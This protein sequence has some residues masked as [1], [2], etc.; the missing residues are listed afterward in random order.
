MFKIEIFK[1]GA[2]Q[3]FDPTMAASKMYGHAN[4]FL[5]AYYTVMQPLCRETGL[6]PLAVDILM[7]VA[8]N[9]E[10]ATARD[11]CRFRGFKPGI[12]SFH[13]DRLAGEGLVARQ[14]VPG[15]RRKTR[16]VCTAAAAPIIDKGRKLQEE[17]AGRILAGLTEQ[18]LENF[19]TCLTAIDRNVDS[20][21]N[22]KAKENKA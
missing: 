20:I 16:L 4:S 15:D 5:E 12:V 6:A 17:F 11:I 9:P 13:V 10:R 2:N 22:G 8:N 21:R 14:D 3:M 7:F 18:Q 1:I 19:H